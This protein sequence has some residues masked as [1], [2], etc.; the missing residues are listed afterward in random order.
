MGKAV[1]AYEYVGDEGI[2]GSALGVGDGGRLEDAMVE[3]VYGAQGEVIRR[4]TWKCRL[5]YK[6]RQPRE[7]RMNA[8]H[9]DP[10]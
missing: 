1:D 7:E 10:V 9:G 5:L 2:G 3:L 8:Q 6:S 4:A